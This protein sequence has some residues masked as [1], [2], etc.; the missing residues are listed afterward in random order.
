MKIKKIAVLGALAAVAGASVAT[1]L[2]SCGEK[3]D[4]TGLDIHLNYNG[5][6]GISLRDDSFNNA[7]ENVN[8]VKGDLLPT[9]KAYQEAVGGIAF[10]DAASYGQSSDNDTYNTI[11]T[12][13]YMSETSAVN[14]IDLFYNATGNIEKAGAAGEVEDL[15][16][17]I[18][19]GSMPNFKKFLEA[20]PTIKKTIT[21]GGKIYYTPYFDGYNAIE[22][23][24]V[25][26]TNMVKKVLDNPDQTKDTAAVQG[27][28][29][30]DNKGIKAPKDKNFFKPFIDADHNYA[31]ATTT[32]KISKNG[33]AS[34]LVI[35]QTDN[36]I[37]QQNT[38]LAAGVSGKDLRAQLIAYLNT[39]FDGQ[40]GEGKTYA[41]LSDIFISEQAAYNTDEL[42][43]LMR[44]IKASSELITG[45][46]ATEIQIM[47]PRG[48]ANNRVDNIADFIKVFGIAGMDG[49]KEMLYYDQDGHLN[50]AAC[51][52]GAYT[53]YD[54]L[55]QLYAEGLMLTDFN[56]KDKG[57]GTIYL[58][59]YFGHTAE[60]PGYG[61]MMYDYSASTCAMNSKVDGV[62]TADSKRQGS[63]KDQKYD[64]MMPVLSPLTYWHTEKGFNAYTEELTDRTHKKL[65]RYEESNRALKSNSWCIPTSADNKA[66]AVAL[67]DYLMGEDGKRINDFGPSQYWK[68]GKKDSYS[69]AGEKTPQFNDTFKDMISKS[70]TDFWSYLRGYLGSTH[71]I[72]YVRSATIN[73]LATN[74]YAQTGTANIENSIAS[75]ASVLCK[76]DKFSTATYDTSV[77]T[78]GYKSISTTDQDDYGAVTAFWAS[79][80]CSDD[81]LGW[82]KLIK[83]KYVVGKT[84][85]DTTELG[86]AYQAKTAYTYADVQAQLE[87]RAK[88]YLAT[89]A[90]DAAP[91]YAK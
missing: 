32:V 5:K 9:W 83:N 37:K 13:G 34:D 28:D 10:R 68:D 8:Y 26:D 2:T 25:M 75:G 53:A 4:P 23:M 60:N 51:T 65:V 41:N 67:M 84:F 90:G 61:F 24:F 91:A 74:K 85:E 88:V 38:S 72:G 48:Q 50:D 73:Y 17:Y 66:K 11:Q 54:Y 42:I 19:D 70:S 76:V 39:A 86:K 44:V 47:I 43:A 80:K 64:G 87:K 6:Q 77:P 62:G 71:G 29:S 55:A 40:V 69:Y 18:N 3:A 33:V 21:K 46:A 22:R 27:T 63:F 82:V 35:K 20:N 1:G 79:D 15:T 78:A 52:K 12:N 81:E 31:A 49:E 89:M 16:P 14:K 56:V 57:N 36:I 7:V 58:N 59:K 30:T 45:D